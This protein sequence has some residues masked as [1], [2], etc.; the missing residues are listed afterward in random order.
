MVRAPVNGRGLVAQEPHL[1]HADA[2]GGEQVFQGR[3]ADALRGGFKQLPDDGLEGVG[4]VA[5]FLLA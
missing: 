4:Q 2:G 3:P 1:V 5:F